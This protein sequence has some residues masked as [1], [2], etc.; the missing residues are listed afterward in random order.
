MPI[1]TA[2]RHVARPLIAR[3][4]GTHRVDLA[5]GG[6]AATRGMVEGYAYDDDHGDKITNYSRPR[7]E[8]QSPFRSFG[9]DAGDITVTESAMVDD[10]ACLLD[11]IQPEPSE[12]DGEDQNAGGRNMENARRDPVPNTRYGRRSGGIG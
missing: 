9:G 8:D 5:V 12:G 4:G 7:G 10:G 2:Q 3:H 11:D 6:E 1:K